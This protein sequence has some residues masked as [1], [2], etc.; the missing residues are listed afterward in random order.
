[1]EKSALPVHHESSLIAES[2]DK[3]DSKEVDKV[4]GE[5]GRNEAATEG[6]VDSG[7]P[8]LSSEPATKP[9]PSLYATDLENIPVLINRGE[10]LGSGVSC[11]AQLTP[12]GQVVKLPWPAEEEADCR[13]DLK[14]EAWVYDK[15]HT[16]YGE[17]AR[18]VRLIS[19]NEE[20]S[21]LVLQYMANGTLR[22]YMKEH[23]SG[24]SCWQRLRWVLAA[25]EAL[26][27]LHAL[28]IIHCD[29]SPKNFLLDTDLEL[30]LADLGCCASV[31]EQSSGCGSCRFYPPTDWKQRPLPLPTMQDDL[32][33]L[34]SSIYNIMTGHR[35]YDD[36]PSDHVPRLIGLQQLPDLCSVDMRD[37]IR[38][39]W[40]LK[41][42]SAHDVRQRVTSWISGHERDS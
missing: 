23:D 37:I 38:D 15:L 11:Y 12:D 9:I 8:I 18:F 25:A 19:F 30:K 22:E 16:A 34:G 39:C 20:T 27:M 6:T 29:F 36:I 17:H 35:P 33:A 7:T 41:A 21:E 2:R 42:E 28:N 32:F 24:V 10:W 5:S 14:K 3:H 31:G 40:L 1:M 13:N 4:N 26:E